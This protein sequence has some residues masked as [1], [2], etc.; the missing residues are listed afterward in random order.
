MAHDNQE[1]SQG[2]LSLAGRMGL[3]AWRPVSG[4][5]PRAGA[6]GSSPMDPDKPINQLEV[7]LQKLH[8]QLW[9]R[10]WALDL[11]DLGTGAMA[12]S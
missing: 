12:G 1:A 7:A 5:T 2:Q 4:G 11:G 10:V 8:S 9:V 3:R 6:G